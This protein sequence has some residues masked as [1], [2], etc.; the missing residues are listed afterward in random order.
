MPIEA[1]SSHDAKP[2]L[3]SSHTVGGVSARSVLVRIGHLL[4]AVPPTSVI[5]TLRPLPI[6]RL[7]G[8]PACVVGVS[9]IRGIATAVI[10]ARILFAVLDPLP[11]ARWLVLRVGDRRFAL[12]VDA[13]LGLQSIE[14]PALEALPPVLGEAAAELVTQIGK[15]DMELLI[16]LDSARLVPDSAWNALGS[17]GVAR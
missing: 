12:A 13:V 1:R 8:M 15:L 5:E 16:V 11:S 3:A 7:P 9:V 6:E 14:G 2:P 10:D 4:A 17:P